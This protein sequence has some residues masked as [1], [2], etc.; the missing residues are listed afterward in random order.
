MSALLQ[1]LAVSVIA[2]GAA[3]AIVWRTVALF[4]AKPGAPGCSS[5]ASGCASRV[6]TN[7]VTPSRGT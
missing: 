2:L 7:R 6:T 1:D 4:A 5:C 3:T